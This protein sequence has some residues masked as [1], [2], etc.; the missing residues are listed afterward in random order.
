MATRVLGTQ[1]RT[2][3]DGANTCATR[4]AEA[5]LCSAALKWTSFSAKVRSP[6]PAESAGAKPV[7]LIELL[8]MTFP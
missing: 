2:F 1:M 5:R 3:F 6:V 8:P 4:I 7:S